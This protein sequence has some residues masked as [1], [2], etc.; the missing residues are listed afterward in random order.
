MKKLMSNTIFSIVFGI[1]VTLFIGVISLLSN[2]PV[3]LIWLFSSCVGIFCVLLKE[4]VNFFMNNPFL[5][6][7]ILFGIIGVIIGSLYLLVCL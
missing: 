1:L 3:N 7:N 4:V 5:Y 2:E 6:K